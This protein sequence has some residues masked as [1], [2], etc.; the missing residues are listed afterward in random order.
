MVSRLQDCYG[1]RR[2]ALRVSL[3]LNEL[4]GVSTGL[5]ISVGIYE[6]HR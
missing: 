2:I 3:H 5:V 1:I 4:S 6:L